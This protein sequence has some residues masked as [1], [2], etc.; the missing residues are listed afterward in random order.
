VLHSCLLLQ[1]VLTSRLLLLLL[2]LK[3]HAPLLQKQCLLRHCCPLLLLL[4]LS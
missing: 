2:L 1:P 3:V 4:P